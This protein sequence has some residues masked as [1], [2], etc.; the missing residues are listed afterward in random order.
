MPEVG[1]DYG[2]LR[3][4]TS[5]D[6]LTILV[7]KDRT[8]KAVLVD[9]VEMKGRGL[10][11]TIERVI[12]NLATLGHKKVILRTDQEPAILD[13]VKGVIEARAEPT[14]P[15]NSPV[16]E[17]QSNGMV[18]RAV[19]SAKDQ[20][21]T[22]RLALMK[23]ISRKVPPRHPTLTWMAQH[24]GELICKYQ[25]N[26]DG[27]TAYDKLMGKPC[28]EEILEFRE[29]VHY[30]ISNVD[31]GSLD[32]RWSTGVWQGKRWRSAEHDVGI[33]QGVVKSDAVKRKPLEDRWNAEAIE[34]ITGTPG[35]L[36]PL[37]T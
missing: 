27:K 14:L 17:S 12:S 1:L 7:M 36:T 13:L 9:V 6:S 32:A 18:E 11:G 20:I 16:G 22:L 34:A 15:E 8:S 10:E 37:P 3:E 26:K 21:R 30:R 35:N 2:F 25:K 19:R 33:P 23:R 28:R 4:S 29:H 24:A 5:E 31:T